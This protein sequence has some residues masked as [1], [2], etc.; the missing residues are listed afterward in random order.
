MLVQTDNPSFIW[1]KPDLAPSLLLPFVRTVTKPSQF[2][3]DQAWY[4]A[5]GSCTHVLKSMCTGAP[6]P[7]HMSSAGGVILC[8]GKRAWVTFSVSTEEASWKRAGRGSRGSVG[9]G[10]AGNITAQGVGSPVPLS[11][12]C[13]FVLCLLGIKP[14]PCGPAGPRGRRSSRKGALSS[15]ACELRDQAFAFMARVPAQPG[16]LGEGALMLPLYGSP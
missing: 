6:I 7:A 12:H 1:G 4:R 16:D 11:S 14:D 3:A 8:D 13:A 10:C 15:W 5:E 2:W 9:S